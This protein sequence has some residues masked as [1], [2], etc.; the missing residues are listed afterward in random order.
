V[1]GV[2]VQVETDEV[3]VTIVVSEETVVE[4]GVTWIT[5]S[6]AKTYVNKEIAVMKQSIKIQ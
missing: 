5:R 1:I 4:K 6:S 3:P 2:T